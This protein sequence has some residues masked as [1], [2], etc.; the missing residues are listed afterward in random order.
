[1]KEN[2]IIEALEEVAK[3]LQIRVRRESFRGE[4]GLCRLRGEPFIIVNRL[5]T[6]A[7]QI[8]ILARS[9]ADVD[10]SGIYIQPRIREEIERWSP[11]DAA[12]A[13]GRAD[14]LAG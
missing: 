3:R 13:G 7:E 4:G 6:P 9:L 12:A 11:V 1:M 5:R 10:L 2:E 14:R 8:E